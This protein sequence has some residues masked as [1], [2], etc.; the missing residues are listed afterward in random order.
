MAL[1][2]AVGTLCATGYA[3]V[4]AGQTGTEPGAFTPAG[5]MSTPRYSHTATL[6]RDGRI[7]LVGGGSGLFGSIEAS[8]EL[9]DPVAR[10]FQPSANMSVSRW[11]HTA[12]LLTDGRVLIVGGF[13]S[14]DSGLV[15][16]A[17]IYDPATNTFT[18]VAT[19]LIPV[20]ATALLDD[21]R[22]LLVGGSS[23]AVYDPQTN[24]VV[25]TG[26]LVEP[27]A[28]TA[29]LL[30]NGTVLVTVS[31]YGLSSNSSY[32]ELYD[33]ATGSFTRVG[34]MVTYHSNP[35]ATLLSNGQVLIVGGD[36]GDG[37]G[38]SATAELYDPQTG[39][40]TRTGGLSIRPRGPYSH[41][42]ERRHRID[43]RGALLSRLRC[44]TAGRRWV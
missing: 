24:S 37:D 41:A 21:G 22:V 11:A 43:H 2:C 10:T 4:A 34:D 36:V 40:F 6:L 42:P 12:T 8:T 44:T 13:N 19:G 1:V 9:Y 33:P 30:Q 32:G 28:G 5:D 27:Y 35:T 38:A 7:L 3:A 17:E 16:S 26:N 18:V 23:A 25:P 20:Q 29:T 14:S 15:T 39:V 31:T